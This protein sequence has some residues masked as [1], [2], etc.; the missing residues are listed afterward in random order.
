MN[1][2]ASVKLG[3]VKLDGSRY[4]HDGPSSFT[5]SSSTSY[6]CSSVFICG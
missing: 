3:G 6:P 4:K 1:T 2:D 5:S